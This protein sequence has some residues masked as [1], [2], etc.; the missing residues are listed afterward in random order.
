ME[1]EKNLILDEKSKKLKEVVLG[2]ELL[3]DISGARIVHVPYF[4]LNDYGNYNR[5]T[6]TIQIAEDLPEHVEQ[7]VLYHEIAHARGIFSE[8]LADAFA[9]A[10]LGYSIDSSFV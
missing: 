5:R 10:T 3:D 8:V 9:K 2:K 1:I 6:N 4:Q 7:F